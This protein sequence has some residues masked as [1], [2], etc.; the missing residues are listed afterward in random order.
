MAPNPIAC[1]HRL[2]FPT[3]VQGITHHHHLFVHAVAGG[4]D[5]QL[6]HQLSADQDWQDDANHYQA[7]LADC[8]NAEAAFGDIELQ[9]Y[10]AGTYVTISTVAAGVANGDNANGTFL[11]SQVTITARDDVLRKVKIILLESYLG[12][13]YR[14]VSVST[15][16]GSIHPLCTDI[17]APVGD[18]DTGF[19]VRSR[20]EQFLASFI[21]VVATDNKQVRRRRGL[22]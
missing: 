10:E 21:S 13:P 19:W 4:T 15:L 17:F 12:N 2:Y 11:A 22:I 16:S 14:K 20:S 8:Y 1:S 7:L 3:V 18:N 5:Y 6:V 9:A